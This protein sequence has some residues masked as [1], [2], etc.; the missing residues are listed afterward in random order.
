M[1]LTTTAEPAGKKPGPRLLF[2]DNLRIVLICL[3]IMV[4][5]PITCGGPGSWYFTGPGNGR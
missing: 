5:C 4:P 3:V 1:I 2:T